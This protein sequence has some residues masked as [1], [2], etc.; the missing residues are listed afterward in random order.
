MP[1]EAAEAEAIK[2]R[3]RW[4]D[5]LSL[6]EVDSPKPCHRLSGR[7]RPEDRVRLFR[8]HPQEGARPMRLKVAFVQTPQVHLRV[9]RQAVEF[10][11]STRRR[12]VGLGDK[13]AGFA[14]T[15]VQRM[16]QPLT[17]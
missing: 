2:L 9:T 4:S 12:R 7:R 11:I 10:F 17:L 14:Q 16:E 8:R 3:L 6:A 15:E 5:Q 13:R 1:K